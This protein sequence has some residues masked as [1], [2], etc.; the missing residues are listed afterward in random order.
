MAD[1]LSVIITT[2]GINAAKNNIPDKNGFSI[3]IKYA[4][5]YSDGVKKGRFDATGIVSGSQ[6]QI[7]VRSTITSATEEYTY[8]EVHLIDGI[9]G[10][11]FATVKRKDGKN[12]DFVS[13]LKKSLLVFGLTFSSLA[14]EKVTVQF[15][16][17]FTMFV[18]LDEHI[19]DE[20]AHH[21]LFAKKVNITHPAFELIEVNNLSTIQNTALFRFQGDKTNLVGAPDE[22]GNPDGVGIQLGF[23]RQRTQIV[24]TG[25]SLMYRNDDSDDN[26]QDENNWK[27]WEK[28][29]TDRN[30]REMFQQYLVP[31]A[32]VQFVA[33]STAPDGWLICNGAAIS[34]T[35]YVDLFAAI[36]TT[37]GNGD[38]ST[39]FN[40][41]DL[42]GE[43]IRGIDLGRGID[44]GR[45]FGSKQTQ[46]MQKHYHGIGELNQGNDDI[47]VISR[48]WRTDE[49][50]QFY[51]TYGNSDSQ[52]SAMNQSFGRLATSDEIINSGE[53]R[54]RNVALLPVIKY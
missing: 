34:R 36:G 1:E 24:D 8:N 4:D 28:I 46:S 18:E 23:N 15:L 13:P 19:K 52:Q 17:N 9:S 12:F 16:E 43:F 32:T 30:F 53:T 10:V 25:D 11:V 49:P 2:A 29:L 35:V 21:E 45:V 27:A 5:V 40:I 7:T 6:N 39:T 47:S 26:L 37:F 14:N 50:F 41:P 44:S 3:V 38:G 22:T 48:Q 42:R 54:P 51:S 20:N 33:R 31:V